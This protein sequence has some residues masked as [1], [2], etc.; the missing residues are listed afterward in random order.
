VEIVFWAISFKGIKFACN[1][2]SREQERLI[3]RKILLSIISVHPS[4]AGR[5]REEASSYLAIPR[6]KF[7]EK[8]GGRW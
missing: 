3:T 5:F 4:R 6:C 7:G 8:G 1:T 2:L